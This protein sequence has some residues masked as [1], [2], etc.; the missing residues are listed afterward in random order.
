MNTTASTPPLK[1]TLTVL[2]DLLKEGVRLG[3]DFFDTLARSQPSAALGRTLRETA[4]RLPLRGGCG[5]SIPQPC[6][7]PKALGE[8]VSHVCPGG[9]ATVRIRVTNCSMA[10]E[11]VRVRVASNDVKADPP[12][13][14]LQPME[15][16]T[17]VLSVTMPA[18]AHAGTEREFLVWVSGCLNHYLRWTVR[19]VNRGADCCHEVEV[20]DCQDNVHHWYDHFYCQRPCHPRLPQ[21]Q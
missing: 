5:C 15:R 9:T 1:E 12:V 18:G 8:I 6:W 16:G 17:S 14:H 21:R 10:R 2:G 11:E 4:P 7:M 19:V 13:L 20:E 3:L